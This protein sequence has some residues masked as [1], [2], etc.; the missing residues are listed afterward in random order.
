MKIAIYTIAKNETQFVERWYNSSKEADYHFIL[1]TGSTDETVELAKSLGINVE[2][3]TFSPWRFDTSRNYALSLLPDDIDLCIALDMD[4]VLVEGWRE[5]LETIPDHITRPR[6][7]YVWSWKEDGSEGLTYGGDKIHRRHGYIWKHP[8]HEVLMPSLGHE[9]QEWTSLQIQHY[10]DN[11]KPRSQYLPLL[12]LAVEEDPDDSRNAFYYARELYFYKI[13]DDAQFQFNRFLNLKTSTWKPE[14]ARAM[15]YLHE[16]TGDVTWLWRAVWECPDRREGWVEL[17]RH[18]YNQH[19][20]HLCFYASGR[21]LL[22]KEKPL[23]YLNEEFA[24]YELPHDL[25]A[26]SSYYIGWYDNALK[27]GEI[28]VSINPE[29]KRLISNLEFYRLQS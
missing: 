24:W 18:A 12:K 29:D 23:E 13:F 4:E 19:D 28:S 21:A 16:I 20:W 6:Y 5:H 26:I 1:D 7:K 8:V 2:V 25:H 3:K 15:R 17:A 27:H 14:R 10:P 11:T 22:I 9:I